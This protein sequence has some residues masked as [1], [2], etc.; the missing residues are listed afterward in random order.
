MEPL[1]GYLILAKNL[2]S[3]NGTKFEGPWNFGPSLRQNL[4]VLKFV[5]IIKTKLKSKSKIKVKRN[6]SKMRKMKVKIF[7]S[8]RLKYK[9]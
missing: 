9:Q 1:F 6:F 4:K 5:K 3:K 2:Y 7:E 8:K